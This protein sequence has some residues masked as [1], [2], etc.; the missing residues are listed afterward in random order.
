MSI[1]KAISGVALYM[2]NF[3]N[4]RV[5]TVSGMPFAKQIRFVANVYCIYISP[6]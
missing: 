2:S 5:V 4:T 1:G 3:V 6:E